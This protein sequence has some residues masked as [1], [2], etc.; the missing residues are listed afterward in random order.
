MFNATERNTVIEARVYF[1]VT[2]PIMSH[3]SC[4]TNCRINNS[5]LA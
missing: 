5:F 1:T 3:I 4:R 2:G